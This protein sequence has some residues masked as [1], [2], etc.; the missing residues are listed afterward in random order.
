MLK[1]E[2]CNVFDRCVAGRKLGGLDVLRNSRG[3]YVFHMSDQLVRCEV[4]QQ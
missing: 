4:T 2:Y 3:S 1:C